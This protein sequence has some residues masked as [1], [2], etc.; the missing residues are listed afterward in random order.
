MITSLLAMAV[1]L[2]SATT[3]QDIPSPY[4]DAIAQGAQRQLEDSLS[5]RRLQQAR[6]RQRGTSLT[7]A[8]R[9]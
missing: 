6:E 9:D 2:A 5:R 3:A 7:A 4:S 1:V 8:D